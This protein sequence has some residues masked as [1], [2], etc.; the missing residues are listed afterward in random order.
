MAKPLKLLVAEER[1]APR[2]ADYDSVPYRCFSTAYAP[3][4][5]SMS[6]SAQK[7]GFDLGYSPRVVFGRFPEV[8]IQIEGRLY[9]AMPYY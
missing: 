7:P 8:T 1:L 2:H 5:A 4:V 6:H 3:R 9:R